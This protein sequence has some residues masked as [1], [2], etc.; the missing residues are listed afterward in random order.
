[1]LETNGHLLDGRLR[2][3]QPQAGFRTGVEPVLLAAAVPARPGQRVLEAGTGAGA[4]LLCLAARVP[5]IEGIGIEIDPAM[6]ALARRNIAA[7]AVPGLEIIVADILEV[8]PAGGFHHAFANPPWH[9]PAATPSPVARRALAKQA[10]V[11]GLAGWVRAL[12]APLLPEGMLTLV[13]PAAMADGA[14]EAMRACGLQAIVRTPLWPKAGRPAKLALVSGRLQPGTD[15][16]APGL[17]LHEAG[18]RFTPEADAVLRGGGPIP[19]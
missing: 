19:A 12:R 8:R 17:V 14:V 4:G 5:G 9:D 3:A 7:N 11:P 2:Y 6:A 10:S 18:G 13:I 15:R 16:V 1:M